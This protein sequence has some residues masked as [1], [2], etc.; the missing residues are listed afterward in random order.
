[1]EIVIGEKAKIKN[2][3]FEYNRNYYEMEFSSN[4]ANISKS[5]IGYSESICYYEKD[6]IFWYYQHG[7]GLQ[8]FNP[9]LGDVCMAC[10]T[11]GG[12]TPDAEEG[13]ISHESKDRYFKKIITGIIDDCKT[14]EALV[15]SKK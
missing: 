15:K 4:K 6:K 11:K 5:N 7:C 2:V 10:E 9:M 8:G 14:L 13:W 1:M 12:A 3:S